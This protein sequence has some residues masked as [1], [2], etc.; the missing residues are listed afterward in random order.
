MMICDQ[1]ALFTQCCQRTSHIISLAKSSIK[2]GQRRSRPSNLS[3]KAR[4]NFFPY[5]TRDK[6]RTASQRG[7]KLPPSTCSKLHITSV[8]SRSFH[9]SGAE[10]ACKSQPF[11]WRPK[12]L[13][14]FVPAQT[15]VDAIQKG[16]EVS[17]FRV[18]NYLEGQLL[19]QK[20]LHNFHI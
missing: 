4:Q 6:S 11:P 19:L 20:K 5:Q 10:Y 16:L 7:K 8:H 2:S 12:H 13:P 18:K 17:N 9:L 3:R 15:L 14:S 1:P